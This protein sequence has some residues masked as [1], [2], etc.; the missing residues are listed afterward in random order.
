M[1]EGSYSIELSCSDLFLVD[2]LTLKLAVELDDLLLGISSVERIFLY[3]SDSLDDGS[4]VKFDLPFVAEGA[5]IF[6]NCWLSVLYFAI[7][8]YCSCCVIGRAL[9]F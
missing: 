8:L 9:G 6:F 5:S 4:L 7:D 3:G 1:D 2:R